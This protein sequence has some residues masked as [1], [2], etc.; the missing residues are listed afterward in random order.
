MWKKEKMLVTS[1]F[2][3]ANNDSKRLLLKPSSNRYKLKGSADDIKVPIVP[4]C[5]GVCLQNTSKF[6]SYHLKIWHL[7]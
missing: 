5:K 6:H 2:S 1:F 4:N 7:L 3:F